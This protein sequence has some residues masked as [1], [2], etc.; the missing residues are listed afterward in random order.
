M[1]PRLVERENKIFIA[2]GLTQRKFF[3]RGGE[4]NTQIMVLITLFQWF[5]KAT[6]L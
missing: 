6:T 3:K 2:K 5:P 1:L 4:V